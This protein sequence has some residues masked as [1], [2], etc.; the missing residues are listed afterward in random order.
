[1][2][3][4]RVPASISSTMFWA[5]PRAS[6]MSLGY[7]RT[8]GSVPISLARARRVR[9]PARPRMSWLAVATIDPVDR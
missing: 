7:S 4:G 2:S 1:M 5:T 9:A 8:P 3:S 6:A